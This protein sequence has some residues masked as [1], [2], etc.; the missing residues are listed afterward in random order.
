[1]TFSMEKIA[2]IAK[3]KLYEKMQRIPFIDAVVYFCNL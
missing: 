3:K 2:T 1:M